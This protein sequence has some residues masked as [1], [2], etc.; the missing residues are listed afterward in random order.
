MSD[1]LDELKDPLVTEAR[2]LLGEYQFDFGEDDAEAKVTIRLWQYLGL[3]GVHF[4]MSHR[5][6]TPEQQDP[7]SPSKSWEDDEASALHTA[8]S[9]LTMYWK[10]GVRAGH[11]PN[12]S[13][14]VPNKRF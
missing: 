13:W 3:E 4:T 9:A 10:M 2:K 1:P 11:T 6:K 5:V 7:Y 14:L 12:A 8:L